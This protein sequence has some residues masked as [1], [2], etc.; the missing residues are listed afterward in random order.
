MLQPYICEMPL[1]LEKCLKNNIHNRLESDIRKAI[2][3]WA[4]L[5]TS[6][7]VLDYECLFN[8]ADDT[9]EISDV[10]DDKNENAESL[11]AIS[12]ED[13][14]NAIRDDDNFSDNGADDE[15]INEVRHFKFYKYKIR[16]EY[17]LG[18]QILLS[19]LLTL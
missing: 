19:L 6:Y 7:T 11:D 9:E 16:G 14:S 17:F 15:P 1:D 5:P 12:D 3:E 8:S 13:N 2:D 4:F 18:L 10:E